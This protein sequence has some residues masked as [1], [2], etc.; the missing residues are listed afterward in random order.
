[1]TTSPYSG[2]AAA[3]LPP[4]RCTWAA[5]VSA[6][7]SVP[8]FPDWRGERKRLFGVPVRSVN[9]PAAELGERQRFERR[10]HPLAV[11]E[12]AR[13]HDAFLEEARRF[14]VLGRRT[15]RTIPPRKGLWIAVVA[16]LAR[17]DG[18]GPPSSGAFLSG[19]SR[20]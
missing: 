16:R 12:L 20:S 9:A 18:A 10:D 15:S 4:A 5:A 6:D 8:W 14:V 11:A 1:V 7:A 3:T 19:A 17:P 2:S 13:N